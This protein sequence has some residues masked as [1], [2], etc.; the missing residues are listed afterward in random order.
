MHQENSYKNF[1]ALA[2]YIDRVGAKEL[3]FKTFMVTTYVDQ[4]YIDKCHIR[5]DTDSR[6]ISCTN[7]NF[8]PSAA[9]E[10][11]ILAE[12]ANRTFPHAVGADS[13]VG[14]VREIEKR[15][16]RVE[17]QDLFE[18]WD[19]ETNKIVMVQRR[20]QPKGKTK[21]YHPWTLFSD[22]VW[23]QM[24]P[25][26]PI[27]F[28]KPKKKISNA[29][30]IHEGG[31]AARFCEWLCRSNEHE[32]KEA[33]KLH[34]WTVELDR[35]EHW[36]I[37]GGAMAPHRANYSE[38]RRE[39][40]GEVV[41]VADNDDAGR[42][43]LNTFSRLYEG[44]LKW[45]K[46]DSRWPKAW[47]L[48]D[49]IPEE[50]FGEIDGRKNYIGPTLTSLLRPATYA[51]ELIPNP[52]GRGRTVTVLRPSFAEEWFHS[53]HPEYFVH[54]DYPNILYPANEFN[55]EMAPF[56]NVDDLARLIRK[57][58]ANKTYSV[59]YVP[60]LPSGLCGSVQGG[61]FIN[62]HVGTPIRETKGDAKPF[63]DY[64]DHLIPKDNDRHELSKWCATLINNPEIKM[65]YGVLLVSET[66]GV[67]K[68]T[69]GQEILK[70]LVGELNVSAPSEKQIVDSQFNDWMGHKR[71][72]IVNEIY[73]GNSSKA[74]NTLKSVISDRFLTMNKKHQATYEIE[75]WLHIFACSNSMRA[76]K[77]SM[78]D[79][80]WLVPRVTENK[81]PHEYWVNLNGWLATGGLGIIKYWARQ[82]IEKHGPVY[83]GQDAPSTDAK[84]EMIEESYSRG[85]NVGKWLLEEMRK[86]AFS[87]G[88]DYFTT[89]VLVVEAIRNRAYD[90]KDVPFLEK[91]LTVRKLA[92]DSGLWVGEEKNRVFSLRGERGRLIATSEDVARR[93]QEILRKTGET[94]FDFNRISGNL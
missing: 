29:I 86:A 91:P 8:A 80:R 85:M 42:R 93:S 12:L 39:R 1:P 61:Q 50:F 60:G 63:T 73:Q 13:I 87:D 22:G 58:A 36:G 67:G 9:E 43:V 79:R 25:G 94:A 53:V 7:S 2:A 33:R 32:A 66:Q 3:S 45:V 4:Y 74:Y 15:G 28:W 71:L 41:Y 65:T 46:F 31:K 82:F 51:T 47:D 19:R 57:D 75:S 18:L 20:F 69:L 38:L 23:R 90:G 64:L 44:Q 30:M 56:S 81:K 83:P 68:T 89:D 88:K 34:P 37:I 40:S 52:E 49:K 6:T 92:K 14:L 59:Q 77:M 17:K 70:P 54:R 26:G 10:T 24:E 72:A 5:I 35:Y 27:P 21:Q 84:T 16:G 55:S 11:A 78:D 62:T 76:L 48:A